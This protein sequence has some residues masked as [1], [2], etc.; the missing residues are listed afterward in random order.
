MRKMTAFL[1]LCALAAS[2]MT[3]PSEAYDVGKIDEYQTLSIGCLHIAAIKAD[4]SLWLWGNG[5]DG[6]IGNGGGNTSEPVKILDDVAAMSCGDTF[7][8]AIKNDGTLWMWGNRFNSAPAKIMDDV[9]A[10]SGEDLLCGVVKSDGTLWIWGAIAEEEEPYDALVSYTDPIRLSGDVVS[11]SVNGSGLA[12]IKKDGTVWTWGSNSYGQRGDGT[13]GGPSPTIKT[14]PTQVQSLSGAVSVSCSKGYCYF[15]VIL[16]D[17]SLWMWGDNNYGQLGIGRT[18]NGQYSGMG[19]SDHPIQTIPVKVMDQISSVF[20]GA[21][22]TAAIKNDGTFWTWGDAPSGMLG[23]QDYDTRY[24]INDPDWI[25]GGTGV[26]TTPKQVENFIVKLDGA[27]PPGPDY[28]YDVPDPGASVVLPTEE[29]EQVKDTG[30]ATEAV[31]TLTNQMTSEQKSSATGM[32]LAALYA[33][34]ATA[35]AAKKTVSGSEVIINAAAVAD[36]EKIAMSTSS[37]VETALV[38]GGVATARYLSNTVTLATNATGKIS[39]KIDPD[40][41]TTEVDKIRVE[42]PTYALTLKTEDLKA[43]LTEILTITME[44]VGA[45]YA[46]GRSNGKVVV[47]VDLPKGKTTDPVTLS[48]PTDSGSTTYQAVVNTA[49]KSTSSKYNPATVTIDGKISSSGSY[50]VQTN[51]KNFTDITN[52]SAEMQAAIRYLASKGII[53]GKT[54]TTFDPDGSINRAEIAALLVRA[55]GKLDNAATNSFTDVKSSDWYYSA[56][57]SSQKNGLIKGYEDKT[58]RGTTTISK[59]QIVAVASRVLMNE[60]GYTAAGNTANYLGKYSDTVDK[61]AQGEVA[62]ATR[63]NLVIYRTDG[64]FSGSKNMTRGDAAII[65]YRLFQRIW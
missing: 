23:Y 50:T 30:T 61:W 51:E 13:Q 44:D 1:M 55:L 64:T 45:G 3:F 22:S 26:R 43:D 46:A 60:M 37:A 57:G 7:T 8:A 31:Q 19:S 10:V 24:T 4:G 28:I 14:P 36:L 2:L 53:N 32:D 47:A 58:F 40:I 49:G 65:I 48:L 17:G 27:V 18:G 12:Y 54:S 21:G 34:T 56:A 63:E 20:C 59:V 15:A 6:Q 52:K 35:K 11:V 29:L 62:L 16:A 39:I 25:T 38:S 9:V 42:T 5:L 41:L 33:E